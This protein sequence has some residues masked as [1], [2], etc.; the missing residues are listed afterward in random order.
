MNV[1]LRNIYLDKFN[2]FTIQ[3]PDRLMKLYNGI[4]NPWKELTPWASTGGQAN[5]REQAV[6]FK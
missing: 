6:C 5:L 2:M 3:S 4:A 1:G